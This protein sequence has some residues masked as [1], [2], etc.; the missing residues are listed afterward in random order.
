MHYSSSSEEAAVDFNSSIRINENQEPQAILIA[1]LQH[2]SRNL[3]TLVQYLI[4]QTHS[5][6]VDGYREALTES[7]D[8][9][10]AAHELIGRACGHPI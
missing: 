3:L 5:A 4:N 1:E 9:L 6:T 2:R 10:A 7:I 8:N